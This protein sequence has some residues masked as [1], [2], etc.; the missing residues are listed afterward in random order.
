MSPDRTH[1]VQEPVAASS[2]PGTEA[3]LQKLI[4]VISRS[5]Q[6]YRDLIDHLDQAVF[7]IS[8]DGEV[9]VANVRL[10]E[11]LGVQFR[12]LI[13]HKITEFIQEPSAT[14]ISRALPVLLKAGTWSGRVSARLIGAPGVR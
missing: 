3:Q 6:G 11:I 4:E 14:A 5:Q 13:G 1:A 9:R 7:T 10:S 12:D 8:L 2:S